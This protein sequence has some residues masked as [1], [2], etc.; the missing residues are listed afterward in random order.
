MKTKSGDFV[1]PGDALG[2]TEEFVPSDWTYEDDGS[3]RSLIAGTVSLDNKNKKISIVPK[4]SS[5]S[6]LKSGV[7]VF[8]QVSDVR[9]QRALIKLDSIKDNNRGLVTSFSGGIHISQSQKGYVAKLTDEFRI[10]DLIEA[11]VTKIIGVDNVDLT[12]AEDELGVLK[13]MCTKCRHYMKQ[14]SK[15][16]VK[17]P[18]CGNKERRNLST[19]YEG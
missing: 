5:P 14:I 8:G 4:T 13:A 1:L 12:T 6:I 2:V 17:C 9:G 3:I 18:N 19:K 11:K 7:V 10:G 16:E 15:N